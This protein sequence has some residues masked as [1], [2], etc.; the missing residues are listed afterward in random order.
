[1]NVREPLDVNKDPEER[2]PFIYRKGS[3]GDMIKVT[4]TFEE[5]LEKV[6]RLRHLPA[7]SDTLRDNIRK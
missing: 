7:L 2:T 3:H 1:M 4:V 5:A 6:R